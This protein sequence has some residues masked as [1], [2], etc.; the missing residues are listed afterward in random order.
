MRARFVIN[1]NEPPAVFE[2]IVFFFL[3]YNHY[4]Y[5]VFVE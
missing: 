3:Q 1:G 5:C 2:Y 4:Y